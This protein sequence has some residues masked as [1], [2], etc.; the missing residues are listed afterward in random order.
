MALPMTAHF[1]FLMDYLLK[2]GMNVVGALLTLITGYGA[3][4]T[5]PSMR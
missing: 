1:E 4:G 2:Y 3:G 5:P